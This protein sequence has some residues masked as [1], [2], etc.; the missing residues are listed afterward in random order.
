MKQ[1]LEERVGPNAQRIG[2]EAD[3]GLAL[4]EIHMNRSQ[5]E[6][7]ALFDAF[8]LG[9]LEDDLFTNIRQF[10]YKKD[11]WFTAHQ[12][13]RNHQYA[14]KVLVKNRFLYI[15]AGDEGASKTVCVLIYVGS[16]D[17]GL[18]II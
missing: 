14:S 2:F 5:T 3:Y 12:L 4:N 1:F 18:K 15:I 6:Y 16:A 17:L 7:P 9:G 8:D 11:D 13:S 10:N